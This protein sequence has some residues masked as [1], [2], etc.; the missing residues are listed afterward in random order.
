MLSV[1]QF[2]V[3][4]SGM[5]YIDRPAA[6]GLAFRSGLLAAV[7]VEPE[8]LG[9]WIDL[10]GGGIDPGEAAEEAVVR[11]FGEETGLRVRVEAELVRVNQYFINT[12]GRP[13]NNLQTVFEVEVEADAPGLKVEHDHTLVWLDPQDALARLRHDSHAWAVA[14][15]LRRRRP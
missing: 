12:D 5:A 1:P 6:F 7:R 8:G 14:A 2:G 3:Q 11:E 15:W 4:S 10:P 9:C 13:F